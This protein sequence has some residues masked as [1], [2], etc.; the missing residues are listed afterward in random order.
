M[1]K[2][3]LIKLIE[4]G[5][6]QRKIAQALNC[7]QGNIKHWLKKYQLKTVTKQFN[8]KTD[9]E[10]FCPKCEIVKPL[11]EFYFSYE[12]KIIGGYCKLCSNAFHTKR[13]RNVKLKMIEYKG[14][15]CKHCNLSVGDSHY[16]VF[17]FHHMDPKTK[18]VNFNKIKYQKWDLI[19]K[20]L[21]KCILLCS[22]CHRL[23]HARLE[24][25]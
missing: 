8:I 2:E 7:S 4:S 19:Q 6:S 1:E 9:I 11:D 16:A 15:S 18:D 21:D 3:I 24:G 13:V 12:G 23:E 25:W 22:N 20:E 5:L 10:K 17:D 14:S